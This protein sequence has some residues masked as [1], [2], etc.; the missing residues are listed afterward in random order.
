MPKTELDVDTDVLLDALN[1]GERAKELMAER[2]WA[3]QDLL[4]RA[5]TLNKSLVESMSSVNVV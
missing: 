4:E 3:E 5:E 2:G 1:D